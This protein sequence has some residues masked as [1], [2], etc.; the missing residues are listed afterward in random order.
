MVLAGNY[1]V[2]SPPP[3]GGRKLSFAVRE[4]PLALANEIVAE[5]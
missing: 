1:R 4:Y 3:P 5:Q 2:K